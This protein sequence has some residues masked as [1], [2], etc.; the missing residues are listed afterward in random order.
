MPLRFCARIFSADLAT[1]MF[2]LEAPGPGGQKPN[3]LYPTAAAPSLTN[4]TGDA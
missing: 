1:V 2:P 3:R 4:H